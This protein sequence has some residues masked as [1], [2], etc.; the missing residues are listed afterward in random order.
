MRVLRRG[1]GCRGENNVSQIVCHADNPL[2]LALIAR[3]ELKKILKLAGALVLEEALRTASLAGVPA[4]LRSTTVVL[5]L[6]ADNQRVPS[7]VDERLMQQTVNDT[8]MHPITLRHAR[9]EMASD[10]LDVTL[11]RRVKSRAETTSPVLALTKKLDH[12]FSVGASLAAVALL[13]V[14]VE[15]VGTPEA[16]VA[17]RLGAR[18]LAPTL[19]KLILVAL[20]VILALKA[21][22]T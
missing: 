4:E 22:L 6:L 21:R 17:T 9:F 19:V 12:L 10:V 20:P 16:A 8:R 3:E 15:R 1:N 14:L 13:V 18:I 2:G 7:L 11:T 5:W